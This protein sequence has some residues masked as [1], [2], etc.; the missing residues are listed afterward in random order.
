MTNPEAP[1]TLSTRLRFIEPEGGIPGQFVN[2]FS[3]SL[4]LNSQGGAPDSLTLVVGQGQVPYEGGPGSEAIGNTSDGSVDI[5]VTLA[6]KFILSRDRAEEL[7][8]T[9]LSAVHAFDL[10]HDREGGE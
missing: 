6:G 2:I 9:V 5:N 1:P 10:A 4:G 8:T 3:V 7:A